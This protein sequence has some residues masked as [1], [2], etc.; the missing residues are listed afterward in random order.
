MWGT[1]ILQMLHN[2][3]ILK[4]TIPQTSNC[5]TSEVIFLV[6]SLNIDKN[7]KRYKLKLYKVMKCTFHAN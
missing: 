2:P 7:E 6:F 5:I 3:I 4:L 1:C